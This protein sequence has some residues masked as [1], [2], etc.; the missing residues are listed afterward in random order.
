MR[1]EEHTWLTVKDTADLL[2]IPLTR[3][4]ELIHAGAL[5]GAV[6]VGE[7]SIRVNR[8]QLEQ[9]LLEERAVT[10]R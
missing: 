9:G 10:Q 5:P 1:A 3:C 8:K 2:Q 4:Y 6:R 7:R